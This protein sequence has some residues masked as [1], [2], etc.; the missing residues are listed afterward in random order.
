MNIKTT[1]QL[2]L[3]GHAANYLSCKLKS[4]SNVQLAIESQLSRESQWTSTIV[5]CENIFQQV[6]EDNLIPTPENCHNF[7]SSLASQTP[8]LKKAVRQEV[9][10]IYFDIWKEKV[11]HL[12]IQGEFVKLLESEQSNVTWKSI[13]YGVPK[14]VMAF[15]MRS[16]TNTLA[17][18]DNLKRWKMVVSDSCKSADSQADPQPRPPCI[19]S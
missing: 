2:Y 12:V 11:E 1:S 5:Q 6:S 9:Q 14:G 15:A 18:P 13:I 10:S 3:E 16:S 17:T 4:D 8:I 7:E 19:T